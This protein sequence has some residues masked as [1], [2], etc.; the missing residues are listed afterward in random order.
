MVSDKTKKGDKSMKYE[1]IKVIGGS[2][3][4]A[5]GS[6]LE[7]TR[8]EAALL[9]RKVELRTTQ[10]ALKGNMLSSRNSKQTRAEAIQRQNHL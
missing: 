5:K 8:Q 2:G 1:L 6:I 4:E 7:G 9:L 10:L 3:G